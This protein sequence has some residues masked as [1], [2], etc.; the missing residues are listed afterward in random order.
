MAIRKINTQFIGIKTQP[1]W[2]C[3][4]GMIK[5]VELTQGRRWHQTKPACEKSDEENIRSIDVR[6]KVM[7]SGYIQKVR[8]VVRQRQAEVVKIHVEGFDHDMLKI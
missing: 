1:F 5:N 2:I 8:V 7:E 6:K 4:N 3:R